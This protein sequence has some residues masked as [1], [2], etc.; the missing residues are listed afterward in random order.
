[1]LVVVDTNILV[2]ALWSRDGAPA[3]VISLIL[4][5]TLVPCYDHR[6]M[7]EYRE[8]L[9]RPKFGFS[10]SEINSLLDWFESIGRSIVSEPCD[11]S[12]IDEA[13]KKFYEVAKFCRAKLIT[14]NLKH[15]PD[16]PDVLSVAEFLDQYIKQTEKPVDY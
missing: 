5:D 11:S 8:V 1:M 7:S 3:K 10:K 14:G 15:F 13:D 6:I 4:N 16:D 12:F 9:E 2:S